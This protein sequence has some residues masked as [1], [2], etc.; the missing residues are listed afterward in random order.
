MRLYPCLLASIVASLLSA[1]TITAQQSW[2][3]FSNEERTLS[4]FLSKPP[5]RGP[6]KTVIYNHG[7]EKSPDTKSDLA[8]FYN[9][10]GFVFFLPHRT[11][12]GESQGTHII[13]RLKPY[14]GKMG[15]WIRVVEQLEYDNKDVVAAVNWLKTQPFVDQK[16]IVM[17]GGSFG[18]I[19][20][21]LSAEKGLGVS[22]FVSFAAA[23]KAWRNKRLQERL[24]KAV[25]DAKA[26]I[27]L[28]QAEN[29]FST[30]PSEVLGPVIRVNNPLN[31]VKLY[32]AFGDSK[33]DGHG[34]FGI[35]K[36]GID[37]WSPDVLSFINKV[38]ENQ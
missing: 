9:K 34:R 24:L 28:I 29:D 35:R 30:R 12:H 1:C 20:A 2:V 15:Y 8:D 11:G 19:Q 32:P 13:D 36:E 16:Y 10:H 14:R 17:S 6:F 38:W 23:A 26:P 4:G 5:G 33:Q 7:S 21:L 37:I 31:R 25:R 18:G 27:F 22:A 3:S